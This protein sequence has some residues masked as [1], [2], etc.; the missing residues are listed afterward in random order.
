MSPKP[1]SPK[2]EL[3][4]EPEDQWNFVLFFHNQSKL[5]NADGGLQCEHCFFPTILAN[6]VKVSLTVINLACDPESGSYPCMAFT[7]ATIAAFGFSVAMVIA[8][9]KLVVRFACETVK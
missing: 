8:S 9:V 4:C 6:L 2:T 7:I 1:V 5:G 3:A